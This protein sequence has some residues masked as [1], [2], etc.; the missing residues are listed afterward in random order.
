MARSVATITAGPIWPAARVPVAWCHGGG[1]PAL[2]PTRLSTLIARRGV[3][4]R[5]R[6]LRV[7]EDGQGGPPS[8]FQ[9]RSA[10][11]SSGIVA[12]SVADQSDAIPAGPS[13]V[14]GGA[15]RAPRTSLFSAGGE[16]WRAVPSRH[17]VGAGA[18][19]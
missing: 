17:W 19:P 9:A 4:L 18:L 12:D 8:R 13:R 1:T 2:C 6:S 15:G 14:V 3:R 7:L 10:A 5:L 16:C 11:I